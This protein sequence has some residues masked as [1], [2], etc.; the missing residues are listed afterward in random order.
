MN[1]QIKMTGLAIFAF[2]TLATSCSD[3]DEGN[4][5]NITI[6]P[7]TD[8]T[9]LLDAGFA[10]KLEDEGVVGDASRITGAE[11][12]KVTV[13][14]LDGNPLVET[15]KLTSL[16][17][18]EV[19][20]NLREL[21]CKSNELSELDLSKNSGLRTVMVENNRLR[22]LVLPAGDDDLEI[23]ECGKNE[24]TGLDLSGLGGLTRVDCSENRLTVLNIAGCGELM[25]L[26]C[27]DNRLESA[28]ISQSTRLTAF[29]CEGNP[30]ADGKMSVRVSF[31]PAS[32]PANFTTGSWQYDGMTVEVD[33]VR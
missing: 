10:Q 24:L 29:S 20:R 4:N 11:V 3:D 30:G 5:D 16:K 9:P 23:L 14:N 12:L 25:T 33:Y 18:I 6:T 1:F 13:L 22:T 27:N 21:N 15:G 2:M 26:Y 28:D 7:T 17:G 8:V 19:F 31:D 32:I